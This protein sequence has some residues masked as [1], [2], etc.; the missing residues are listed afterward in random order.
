MYARPGARSPVTDVDVCNYMI[1][2][3]RANY[4]NHVGDPAWKELIDVLCAANPAFRRLW[5]QHLVVDLGAP[6][7]KAFDC[8]GLGTVRVR[9]TSFPLQRLLD[10]RMVVYLPETAAD[11]A[12]VAELRSRMKRRLRP[13]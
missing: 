9:A 2:T 3:L 6:M 10:T 4:A 13:A 7:S 11:V 8:F 5:E 1:A 12:L